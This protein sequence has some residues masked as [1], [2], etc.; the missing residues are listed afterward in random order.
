[1]G[2]KVGIWVGVGD[3]VALNG[4]ADGE[5]V[6][7]NVS[8]AGADGEAVEGNIIASEAEQATKHNTRSA[9]VQMLL[10]EIGRPFLFTNEL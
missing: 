2:V 10:A 3:N 4:G 7:G 9:T 6:G 8:I 1:M 5:T